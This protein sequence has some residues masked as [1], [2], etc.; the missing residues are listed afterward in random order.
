VVTVFCVWLGITAKRARDQKQAVE[1]VLEMGG[2]VYYQH[3]NFPG[4]GEPL[5]GRRRL[6]DPPGPVWLRQIIGN[7]YFFT[8]VQIHLRGPEVNDLSMVAV[9]RLT[10]V[11]SLIHDAA[12]ITDA[13][14][15]NL[16]SLT[17]L[18]VLSLFS[19]QITDAGLEHLKGLSNLQT[20]YLGHNQ[21][22]DAGLV[23]LKGLTNL[24]DLNLRS[25]SVTDEG[26]QK[27]QQALPNCRINYP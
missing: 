11:T 20:L 21:I 9:G 18:Q 2:D 24:K 10:D 8:V 26:V 5:P 7:E 12:N 14:L 13:G 27:L 15:A 3:A 17:N 16:K 4:P 1:A 22:T 25:T 23:H 6:G 19:T